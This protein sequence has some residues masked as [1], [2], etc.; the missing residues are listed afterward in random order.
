MGESEWGE[1]GGGRAGG[2]QVLLGERRRSEDG[3]KDNDHYELTVTHPLFPLVPKV[4]FTPAPI[5]MKGQNTHTR[6]NTK[7][8][9]DTRRRAHTRVHGHSLH[10][11]VYD[12]RLL[13]EEF[14]F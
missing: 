5:L 3:A 6:V 14:L 12:S 9:Q 4:M 1:G 11:C 7:H 2:D 13:R 10:I 8:Q